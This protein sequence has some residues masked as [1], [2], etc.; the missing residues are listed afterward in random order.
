MASKKKVALIQPPPGHL[1]DLSAVKPKPSKPKPSELADLD[2][3]LQQLGNDRP[4]TLL[5]TAVDY[6]IVHFL[7]D[8]GPTM[9]TQV[10]GKWKMLSVPH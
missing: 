6:W 2:F 5:A 3:V 9:I 10:D 1:P 7:G 8:I 4:Y